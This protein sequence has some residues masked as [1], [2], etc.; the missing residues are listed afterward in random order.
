MVADFSFLE[1]GVFLF[2]YR[3][4]TPQICLYVK[5][6]DPRS[7]I[8][9]FVLSATSW[10]D[11]DPV[12]PFAIGGFSKQRPH[13]RRAGPSYFTWCL[14]FKLRHILQ[15]LI[16]ESSTWRNQPETSTCSSTYYRIQAV[17]AR[18]LYLHT[19]TLADGPKVRLLPTAFFGS[20][21]LSLSFVHS[22]HVHAI[23][24]TTSFKPISI[25]STA[26]QG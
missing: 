19:A 5:N 24:R 15:P 10:K 21:S 20:S 23:N 6:R 8:R 17:V 16:L 22:I 7:L 14:K 25:I 13:R 1:P 9:L 26:G 2:Q 12:L 4:V 18:V 11:S 3:H